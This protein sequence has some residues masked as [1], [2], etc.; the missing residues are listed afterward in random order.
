M[1]RSVPVHG[2]FESFG[3]TREKFEI[4]GDEDLDPFV[5]SFITISPSETGMPVAGLIKGFGHLYFGND[6]VC[7]TIIIACPK[8]PYDFSASS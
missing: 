6:K 1:R 8:I 3:I 2:E 5:E 7:A 4:R